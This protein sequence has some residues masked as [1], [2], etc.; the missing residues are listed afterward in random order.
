MLFRQI[1][2]LPLCVLLFAVILWSCGGNEAD[3][4]K[5]AAD[6]VVSLPIPPLLEYSVN[7]DGEKVF[8]L[9]VQAGEAQLKDGAK[10]KT[11]SYTGSILGPTI[12]VRNH[13]K[14]RVNIK[15]TLNKSTTNHWHGLHLP[16]VQDGG[17]HQP[18]MPGE[19]WT[20][21]FT[22]MQH[23][24]TFWYHPHV[25]EKTGE[26]VYQGMAGLFIVDT[27]HSDTLSLPREYGV[28]DIPLVIQDRRLDNNNQL[29][30]RNDESDKFGVKGDTLLVN[31]AP[32][33]TFETPAQWVRLRLLNGSNARVY[34]IGLSDNRIFYQIGVDGSMLEKP[35]ALT[36][37]RLG[38]AER[39]E[40]VVD[41]SHDSGKSLQLTSFS[42]EIQS[43]VQE[44]FCATD[45]N[46]D[47]MDG[48]DRGVFN[49]M[50]FNVNQTRTANAVNEI[51]QDLFTFTP[52]DPA[53]A[54]QTRQ[55]ALKTME[56]FF[57]NNKTMDMNRIDNEVRLGDTEIWEITSVSSVAHPFHI[58]DITFQII[59]RQP[60]FG[61]AMPPADNEKGWKDTVY[62]EP[63]ETVRIIAKFEACIDNAP[64]CNNSDFAD[65]DNAYMYHC[66][67]LEHEDE[68]MM[69]QF[70]VI[71]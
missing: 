39:A 36:R 61:D 57:I 62:I 33:P 1:Y 9:I 27:D 6:N 67:I 13:D 48:L 3:S 63:K 44:R 31:G 35:V 23:A 32:Q 11:I 47:G 20:S 22:V 15:N 68:G 40:I 66:H 5:Q 16:A 24:A 29:I 25:M 70:V 45:C 41:F 55:F 71:D 17:P 52:I 7:T 18:I 37:V 34:N 8:N 64:G 60:Q 28:D 43:Q 54:D 14:I 58:H 46:R 21:H 56:G 50:T 12:R 30:Y 65:P 19:T 59:D 4:T 38:P 2:L 53:T 26:Q 49:L 42:D 10:T 69:G 51:S